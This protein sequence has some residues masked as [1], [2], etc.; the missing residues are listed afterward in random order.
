MFE[1]ETVYFGKSRREH[2]VA[3]SRGQAELIARMAGL[4]VTGEVCVPNENAAAMKRLDRLN[5]RHAIAAKRLQEL[6]ESRS[7]D[8]DTGEQVFNLLER[9]Y[10]LGKSPGGAAQ[11]Q[12]SS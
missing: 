4:G 3:G 2:F 9:W 5:H 10:V 11:A 7:G 12:R 8:S 6:V 1:T